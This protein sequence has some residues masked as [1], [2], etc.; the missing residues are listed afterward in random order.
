[1]VFLA[2]NTQ[3]PHLYETASTSAIKQFNNTG[4]SYKYLGEQLISNSNCIK[5]ILVTRLIVVV[6]AVLIS[7]GSLALIGSARELLKADWQELYR[8]GKLQSVYQQIVRPEGNGETSVGFIKAQKGDAKSQEGD[9]KAQEGD[10]KATRQMTVN[11]HLKTIT[12]I[13]YPARPD[14]KIEIPIANVTGL[15]LD[16]LAS[17][18][19]RANTVTLHQP[20]PLE[21]QTYSLER[22]YEMSSKDN[23][24]VLIH[25]ANHNG[26]HGARKARHVEMLTQLFREHGSEATKKTLSEFTFQELSN[27]ML[28]AYFMRAGRVDESNFSSHSKPDNYYTR[29]AEIYEAYAIQLQNVPSQT[30]EWM[31]LLLVN[32]SQPKGIRSSKIDENPKSLLAHEILTMAHELDL[33]RCFSKGY[34]QSTE[35]SIK[36]ALP[37]LIRSDIDPNYQN[38][39]FKMLIH[40]GITLCKVTGSRITYSR[41][42]ESPI[43]ADFSLN[44]YQCWEAVQ[45]TPFPSWPKV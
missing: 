17:I 24:I 29:S 39:V 31:K 35:N 1:M 45:A 2:I 10:A 30:I 6:L 5:I 15:R 26:T 18:F 13:P 8:G 21:F 34:F 36:G 19:Q 7:L 20:Y 23:G 22:S 25:R 42:D 28:A 12:G 40:Y 4:K 27:L 44:G 38:T 9:A 14:I 16:Q 43:F 41:E 3:I 11:V 32:S 37:H 33:V